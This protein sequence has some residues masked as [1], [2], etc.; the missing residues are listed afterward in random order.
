VFDAP[1][2]PGGSESNAV[3]VGIVQIG[4]VLIEKIQ[5]QWTISAGDFWDK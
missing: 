1:P 5:F 3:V 2:P 4:P